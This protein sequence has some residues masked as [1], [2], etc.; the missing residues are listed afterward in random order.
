MAAGRIPGFPA[1]AGIDPSAFAVRRRRRWLPRARGD[2]PSSKGM[3][4]AAI[5]A[6]P[7][8][9]GSTH[10]EPHHFHSVAGFPAHAGI[11]PRAT[12]SF[13]R[14][15]R[16]PRARGDR[17]GCA[18][19]RLLLSAASPRTR[20]STARL[21]PA[22][23]AGCGFPAHAGIDPGEPHERALPRRLPRARGDRP[24]NTS[25]TQPLRWAS[26]R[27]RGSTHCVCLV[28]GA[29][30]GFPAH[31]G[32][33]PSP[34]RRTARPTG[35]PRARGDRPYTELTTEFAI[36]ASPRTR[37]STRLIERKP[38]MAT[39]F[40]AHAGIDRAPCPSGSATRRLPRARGDRP[41]I[42]RRGNPFGGASPRTRGSTHSGE[43]AR[44]R[45]HGFP[46]HAG[47]D[48]PGPSRRAT[49]RRLPRARGD[50]PVTLHPIRTR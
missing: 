20:G 13:A 41:T 14:W 1:H 5:M 25:T 9:R 38:N 36:R 7:R 42:G 24:L 37:G 32:I 43:A 22:A 40:P 33:D 39:G 21:H 3:R 6:S 26:P 10:I 47:I 44:R 35:L 31:A 23:R 15:T 2:R 28:V 11:D 30:L 19:R 34:P 17:P 49:T 27:T 12:R 46:A 48:P 50:R 18:M 8:T 29:E 4:P 45:T 16:L